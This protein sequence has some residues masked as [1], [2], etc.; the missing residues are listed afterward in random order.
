VRSALSARGVNALGD[1]SNEAM[2]L[3]DDLI[4]LGEEL[5]TALLRNVTKGLR[6]EG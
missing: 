6:P 2:K 3:L 1:S 4:A 5:R